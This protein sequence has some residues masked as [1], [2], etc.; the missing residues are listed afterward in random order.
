MRRLLVLAS[1]IVFVDVAFFAAITPLLPAY[2][3]ELGLSRGEA[4]ILTASY[5]AGTLLASLPAGMLVVRVGHRAAVLSGLALL[6]LA[7]LAF[8]FAD[9]ALA[10]DAARFG[11][12]VGSALTWA[13]ALSWLI[14]SAPADRRGELIG[15]AFGAA[16]AGALMGPALG[17]LADR[18]GT[19]PVF[20][21]VI[22]VAVVLGALALRLP[23]P[24]REERRR[25]ALGGLLAAPV[26]R[27]AGLLFMPSLMFGAVA[28]LVPLRID[29]L[30]G[31]A[32]VVAAGFIAGAALE[33]VLSPLVGRFSDRRGRRAPI[34]AG[35][36]FCSAGILV[37]PIAGAVGVVLA[38]LI[39]VSVGAGLCF[40]PAMAALSDEAEKV[41]LS[42]ALAAG[43]L[44]MA[45]AAGQMSG[46]AGGGA[47]AE[48]LG[49]GVPCA[50]L[51]AALAVTALRIAPWRAGTARMA[52]GAGRPPAPGGDSP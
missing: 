34:G 20:G 26:L 50:A 37:V 23:A 28:V 17:G 21:S 14:D 42:Q 19:E 10:L 47:A 39:V 1:V 41:G 30:G 12:G 40:S 44:N 45:W 29:E 18:V 11:Q 24:P 13:G 31:S 2:V 7:S 27:G 32:T 49:Y 33:T 52:P 25:E 6:G 36:L 15:T 46:S 16:V 3:E 4:G 38:A 51:A 43:L 5:A 22:V 48:A 8:G 35:L 9:Q